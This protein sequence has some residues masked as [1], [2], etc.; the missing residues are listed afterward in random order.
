MSKLDRDSDE[1]ST[2]QV[3][4]WSKFGRPVTRRNVIPPGLL[5]LRPNLNQTSPPNFDLSVPKVGRN[6]DQTS[7]RLGPNYTIHVEELNNKT[8]MY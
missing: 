8:K 3:E 1:S 2:D 5:N 7:T 4:V 6:F